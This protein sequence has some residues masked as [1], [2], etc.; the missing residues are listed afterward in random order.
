M[1]LAVGR[2][3]ALAEVGI[4]RLVNGPESFTPDGMF[5]LGEA[6]ELRNCFVGA[7]FN[8]FGIAAGGGAGMALAEWVVNGAPPYDLWQ[9]DIRRFGRPHR[10]LEWVRTRTLEA[11]A[12]HY[13]MAWPFEEHDSGRPCRRSPLVRP[14]AGSRARASARSS[15][16]SARTG[17]PTSTPAR[18]PR[19]RYSYGRQNWFAR[20]R[21]RA[22]RDARGGA[23][24]IDQT[25]FAKF[26]LK[27]PDA[28]AALQWLCANDVDKPV[29]AVTYTQMLDAG[30][31]IQ[32]DVT[33]ARTARAR[34]PDRHRHRL[35]HPRLRLDRT[36]HPRRRPTP[37]CSTS[38]RRRRCW[39]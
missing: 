31:G 2:V 1:E 3:P 38:R 17:S 16:G 26:V 23:G 33:V 27:G 8:A 19:D 4:N 25:S 30:G 13:T 5:I 32:C 18:R 21:A 22:P 29:G 12:K 24:L 20:G 9:A 36:Q 34:V 14:L 10:S 7:G 35:R 6:P 37:S 11:Y 28:L 15:A 39:R